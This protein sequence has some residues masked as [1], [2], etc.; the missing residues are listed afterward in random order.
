M[1]NNIVIKDNF[2]KK[3]DFKKLSETILSDN[4]S[5]YYK[6]RMVTT[7]KDAS[8]FYHSFFHNH[9]PNSNKLY[10]LKPILDILKPLALINIR[11]NLIIKKPDANSSYH[12]DTP[13]AKTSI[14]YIN[15]NNG[16]T[17]FE[18]NNKKIN[19]VKNRMLTFDSNLRHRAVAQSDT[20]R[21]I[22]INFNYF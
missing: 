20:D 5:W 22:V 7:T 1:K 2:I 12:I 19:C 14:F 15:T 10:L 3:N 4:F 18:N 21:R 6:D 9:T 13:N 16:H 17:E 8:F 11:A